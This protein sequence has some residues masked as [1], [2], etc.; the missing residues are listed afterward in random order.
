M[1]LE[2]VGRAFEVFRLA[3]GRAVKLTSAET[4]FGVWLCLVFSGV[5]IARL[6]TGPTPLNPT[7]G[8]RRLQD[9][10]EA[11]LMLLGAKRGIPCYM[12]LITFENGKV[13][14]GSALFSSAVI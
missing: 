7:L 8:H 10:R 6:P 14:L 3:S 11:L 5:N 9:T 1:L 2:V 13:D 4:L 12:S